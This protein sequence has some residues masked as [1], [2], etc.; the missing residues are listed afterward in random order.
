M[1]CVFLLDLKAWTRAGRAI[2]HTQ[3]LKYAQPSDHPS[4]VTAMTC[5]FIQFG[6]LV[7]YEAETKKIVAKEVSSPD[8]VTGF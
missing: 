8:H 6:H 2:A 7:A 1:N 3:S 5:F 4:T